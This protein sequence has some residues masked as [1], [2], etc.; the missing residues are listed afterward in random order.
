MDSM[1]QLLLIVPKEMLKYKSSH[2]PVF[3]SFER[4]GI[5]GSHGSFIF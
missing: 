2:N 5:A 3:H 1:L 4:G